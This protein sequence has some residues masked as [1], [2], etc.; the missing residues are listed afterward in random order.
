MVTTKLRAVL[1]FVHSREAKAK[2][3]NCKPVFPF[4]IFAPQTPLGKRQLD[5]PRSCVY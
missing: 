3:S 1:S 2:E 4:I 5:A